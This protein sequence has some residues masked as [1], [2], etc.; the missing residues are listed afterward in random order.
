MGGINNKFTDEYF[1]KK[2]DDALF[3]IK[4]GRQLG[5]TSERRILRII[6]LALK[7][8]GRDHRHKA[9]EI[10]EDYEREIMNM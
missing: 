8:V 6:Y 10:S 5:K 2:A 7:E 9:A 4:C 1:D 3:E